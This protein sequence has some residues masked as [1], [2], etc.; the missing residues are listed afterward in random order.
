VTAA[1]VIGTAYLLGSIPFGYL[2]VRAFS[3]TD[4]RSTGSGNI[5]ATNALRANKAAG[6][7]TLLLDAGKGLLAVWLARRLLVEPWP[8]VAALAAVAGHVFPL[9]FGFRGGKGVATGMGAFG[10]LAPQAVVMSLA[11]FL[12]TV[13][14][15]RYVSVGSVLTAAFFPLI[16]WLSGSA[17]EVVWGCS[18]AAALIVARHSDNIRRLTRGQEHRFSLAGRRT[19]G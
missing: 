9:F 7:L 3:G 16:A 1:L 14:I 17:A 19:G 12:A 15:S 11:L 13:L 2:L 4:I 8:V 10:L 5:G 6:I 18:V